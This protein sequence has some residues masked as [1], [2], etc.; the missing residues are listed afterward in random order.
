M[1]Q[2]KYLLKILERFKM[3][4]CKPKATPS[5]QKLEFSDESKCDAKLYRE[6]VGSLIYTMAC[7]RPDL[8]WVVTKL[9]HNLTNPLQN[10]WTAVKHAEIFER[11]TGI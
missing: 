3:S 10:D 8:C 11:H 5:E 2:K 9:S 7:T 1:S 4:N 6:A